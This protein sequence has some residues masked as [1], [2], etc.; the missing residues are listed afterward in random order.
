MLQPL[1]HHQGP[2]LPDYYPRAVMAGGGHPSTLYNFSAAGAPDAMVINLGTNDF[3][4]C[5][6]VSGLQV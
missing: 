4:G 1:P 5:M 6:K 2:T 3:A